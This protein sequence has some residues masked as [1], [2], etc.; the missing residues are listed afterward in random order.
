MSTARVGL[1]AGGRRGGEPRRQASRACAN[2]GT[3]PFTYRWNR[4]APFPGRGRFSRTCG[5]GTRARTEAPG[6]S[7]AGEPPPLTA[8]GRTLKR[9]LRR[10]A[11]PVS[12]PRMPPAVAAAKMQKRGQER[13]LKKQWLRRRPSL[14]ASGRRAEGG[15]R[16]EAGPD[17]TCVGGGGAGPQAEAGR[18]R[19]D[20][21]RWGAVLKAPGRC[22]AV[23]GL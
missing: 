22:R 4:D 5:D 8:A 23:G 20:G 14:T 2:K 19:P 13:R 17:V 1:G 18:P 9:R 15:G 7:A 16:A 11:S 3:R 10:G 21:G 12:Y 6:G